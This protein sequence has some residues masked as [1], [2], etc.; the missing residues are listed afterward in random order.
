MKKNILC[1]L[2][3]FIIASIP[4]QVYATD[5]H[6]LSFEQYNYD[7]NIPNNSIPGTL[8]FSDKKTEE[9]IASVDLIKY[10]FNKSIEISNINGENNAVLTLQNIDIIPKETLE[11]IEFYSG[12][13]GKN[14]TVL[15][16]QTKDN[17]VIST[18]TIDPANASELM[19]DENLYLNL[20]TQSIYTK[21]LFDITF[22]NEIAIIKF[23]QKDTF[24]M[25]TNISVKLDMSNLDT[26]KKLVFYSYNP[27][28]F[29]LTPF[30]TKYEITKDGYINF[31]T[32]LANEIIISDRNIVV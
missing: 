25:D 11:Y 8:S 6:G 2:M 26:S 29:V 1:L 32:I 12:L 16:E 5:N 27:E 4:S 31:N 14:T 13:Y 23:A 20:Q 10:A 30:S 7:Y 24:N 28:T 15:V 18:I 22:T 17:K 21:N 19:E 9:T 3:T